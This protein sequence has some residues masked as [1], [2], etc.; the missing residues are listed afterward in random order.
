MRTYSVTNCIA[1]IQTVTAS[2]ILSIAVQG[3]GNVGRAMLSELFARGVGRVI[4]TDVDERRVA[5]IQAE[6]A[7]R[8]LEL[9]VRPRGDDSVLRSE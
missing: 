3:V 8:P 7:G 5:E 1:A 4:A 9:S 6:F 2:T